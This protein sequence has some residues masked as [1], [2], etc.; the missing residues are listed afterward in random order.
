MST[1]TTSLYTYLAA[2]GGITALAST[3]IYPV[4]I[5]QNPTFPLITYQVVST[6]VLH[7]LDGTSAPNSRIQ[8][9]C[10][11]ETALAA[12]GLADA[13]ETALDNYSGTMNSADVVSGSLLINRQDIFEEDVEDYRVLLE[14]SLIH[15]PV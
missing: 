2:D 8:I 14:F 1:I 12:H 6:P 11:A 9:D 3:R 7:T 10:W 13:V 4:V 15:K 5:P